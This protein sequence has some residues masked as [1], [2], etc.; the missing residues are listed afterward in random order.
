MDRN[1]I[2][3]PVQG[4]QGIQI[5]LETRQGVGVKSSPVL[6]GLNPQLQARERSPDVMGNAIEAPLA[7][8]AL[9]VERLEQQVDAMA[10]QQQRSDAMAKIQANPMA[11][12]QGEGHQQFIEG[13][14]E[15]APE[16]EQQAQQD[17]EAEAQANHQ[18]PIRR[19]V[20]KDMAQRQAS[21]HHHHTQGNANQ[22]TD[23]QL[24]AVLGIEEN[25]SP[26]GRP[27]PRAGASIWQGRC[28]A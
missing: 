19:G 25:R 15:L 3:I 16:E 12:Q 5:S 1:R 7:R 8:F 28:R 23:Q 24:F 18:I 26:H 17:A 10:E 13:L 21:R 20:A 22:T 11:H 2:E 27:R 9:A 14:P 6:E 4:Q